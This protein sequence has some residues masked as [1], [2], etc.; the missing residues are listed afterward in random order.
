MRTARAH[1]R[2]TGS[3]DAGWLTRVVL[4]LAV[5]GIVAVDTVSVLSTRISVSDDAAS[6]AI[7]GRDNY[8]G[9][10]D[11]TAAYTAA[12]KAAR[13]LHP[14]TALPAGGFLVTKDGTVTVTAIRM[15]STIVAH[16]L[17]WVRD[18][19]QQHATERALPAT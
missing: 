8:A 12:Q 5:V 7:A 6:A 2:E 4:L 19:L 14:A 1:R 9:S 17:P 11:V 15:P 3:I 13:D 16:Y 10:H 18:H